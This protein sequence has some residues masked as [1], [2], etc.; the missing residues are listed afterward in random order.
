MI[1]EIADNDYTWVQN[2]DWEKHNEVMMEESDFSKQVKEKG[3][4]ISLV[5]RKR[6]G[7]ELTKGRC[8]C[9]FHDGENKTSLT[10]NDKKNR[11]K[12]WSCGA[13][14]NLVKFIKMMEE[15]KNA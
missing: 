14:G 11:F 12:C 10:L 6:Y 15:L 8:K 5:A 4:T 1:Y 7:L 3:L 9:P 13:S 2:Y